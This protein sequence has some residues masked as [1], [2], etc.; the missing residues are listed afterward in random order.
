MDSVPGVPTL[1]GGGP[2]CRSAAKGLAARG[3]RWWQAADDSNVRAHRAKRAIGSGD[4]M[5]ASGGLKGSEPYC[6]AA[7]LD[8][9]SEVRVS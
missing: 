1:A 5:A 9:A 6:P 4:D 2:A 3:E 7:P 8:A